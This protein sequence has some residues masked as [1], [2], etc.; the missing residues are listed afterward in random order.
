MIDALGLHQT[1]YLLILCFLII[2]TIW[3]GSN[4]I[5][6][7]SNFFSMLFNGSSINYDF[8]IFQVL[9]FTLFFCTHV[10]RSTYLFLTMAFEK[11]MVI[12]GFSRILRAHRY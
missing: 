5:D 1:V 6:V 4:S 12:I 11:W 8:C 10:Q 2:C 9:F 3:F 7:Y